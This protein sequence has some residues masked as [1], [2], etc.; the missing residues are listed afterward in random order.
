MPAIKGKPISSNWRQKRI[1]AY[2]SLARERKKASSRSDE[3]YPASQRMYDKLQSSTG[4][5]NHR[6]RKGIVEPVYGWIKEILGFRR[7]SLKGVEKVTSEWDLVCLATNL[8]RRHACLPGS[9]REKGH[10]TA[11]SAQYRKPPLNS[12]QP[13]LPTGITFGTNECGFTRFLP[14]RLLGDTSSIVEQVS[15]PSFR[16][17]GISP[18]SR[19]GESRRSIRTYRAKTSGSVGPVWFHWPDRRKHSA[20]W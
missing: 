17:K 4:R 3:R 18:F 6:K 8:K 7:F 10:R 12:G 9:R 13:P 11:G 16:E 5:M 19:P 20:D 14:R 1:D 15:L 2:V